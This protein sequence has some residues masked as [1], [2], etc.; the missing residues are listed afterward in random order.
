MVSLCCS[1]RSPLVSNSDIAITIDGAAI[2][3][4]AGEWP[5]RTTLFAVARV[6][7]MEVADQLPGREVKERR[8]RWSS[9][10]FQL[11]YNDPPSR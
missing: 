10:R 5:L 2:T 6:L 7:S 3:R 4:T 1:P 8:A 9:G 11:R